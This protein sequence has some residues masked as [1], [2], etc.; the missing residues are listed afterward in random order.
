MLGT[1]PG[2]GDTEKKPGHRALG[3][4]TLH[5]SE[6]TVLQTFI[7]HSLE[8]HREERVSHLVLSAAL[9]KPKHRSQRLLCG[10]QTSSSTAVC[11]P[12]GNAG[13][14]VLCDTPTFGLGDILLLSIG[15]QQ[16]II[17][18]ALPHY[19]NNIC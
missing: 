5:E 7:A 14:Y 9:N 16:T 2:E 10:S 1:V 12:V 4:D 15:D 3:A 13:V 19:K 8:T 17:L 11:K 6:E 18:K